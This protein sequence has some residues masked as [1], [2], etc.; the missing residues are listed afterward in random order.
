VGRILL[1]ADHAVFREALKLL[2]RRDPQLQVVAEAA[3]ADHALALATK[4]QPDIILLD[5]DLGGL[6]ALDVVES[7]RLSAPAARI[8]LLGDV[9][10][11]DLQARA[12]GLGAMGLVLREQSDERLLEAI[13]KVRDGELWFD[14]GTVSAAVIRLMR[15]ASEDREGQG[16]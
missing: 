1:I 15:G 13:Q 16:R 5:I 9:K 6:D 14:R 2:L 3:D 10:E 8:I 4:E 12:L 7:L 11:S